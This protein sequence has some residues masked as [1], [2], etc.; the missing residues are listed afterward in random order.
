MKL[1]TV[2]NWLAKSDCA[3]VNRSL[4]PSGLIVLAVQDTTGCV[5]SYSLESFLDYF[6]RYVADPSIHVAFAHQAYTAKIISIITNIECL[7]TF[8]RGILD[9]SVGSGDGGMVEISKMI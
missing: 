6:S 4:A 9:P 2:E 8:H 5:I 3:E 7:A 1:G